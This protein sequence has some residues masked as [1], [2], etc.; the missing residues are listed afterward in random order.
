MSV[1]WAKLHEGISVSRDLAEAYR[2][3]RDAPLLFLM[4]LPQADV[5]GILMGDPAVLRGR[6][7]PLLPISPARIDAALDALQ[8]VGLIVRYVDSDGRQ[9]IWIRKWTDYQD[10]RWSRVGPPDYEPPEEWK[11]PEELVQFAVKNPDKPLGKWFR[12]WSSRQLPDTPGVSGSV[13]ESPGGSRITTA[14][15]TAT[16]TATA[17]PPAPLNPPSPQ[18]GAGRQGAPEAPASAPRKARRLVV[19]RDDGLPEDPVPG[20]DPPVATDRTP[21]HALEQ[22]LAFVLDELLLPLFSKHPD[23]HNGKRMRWRKDIAYAIENGEC[24]IDEI[25]RWLSD[26]ETRPDS[27]DMDVPRAWLRRRY[28]ERRR[29]SRARDG[30]GIKPPEPAGKHPS[31]RVEF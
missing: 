29:T 26:P 22:E 7:C 4:M 12:R 17:S 20:P 24:T 27:A 16:T 2:R 3:S 5:Y 10:I 31:G 8:D 23:W 28:G 25:R 30:P 9:L 1:R 21:S 13:P 19:H 18:S 15:V 14:T 6:V 11:A